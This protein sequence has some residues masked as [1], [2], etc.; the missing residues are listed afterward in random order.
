MRID[1]PLCRH[2]EFK[3][4]CK[5]Y[6]DGNCNGDIRNNIKDCDGCINKGMCE[7]YNNG[8]INYCSEYECEMKG[9]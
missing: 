3:H 1:K 8:L 4:I 9:K 6:F 7:N 5:F 2:N